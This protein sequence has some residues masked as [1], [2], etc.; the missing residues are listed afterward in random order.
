M[1]S[2]RLSWVIKELSDFSNFAKH[3]KVLESPW[4]FYFGLIVKFV[5]GIFCFPI[6]LKLIGGGEFEVKEFMT[7]YIYKEIFVDK[8]YDLPALQGN[9][10]T[11]IDVGANTGLF[12]IR[13]K[14]Q[15]NNSTLHCFEPFPSN[16]AQLQRNIDRSQLSDV[17]ISMK[18]VGNSARKQKLFVHSKNVGGHSIYAKATDGNRYVDI[19]LVDIRQIINLLNGR[20]CDLLKLDCEGAEYEIIKSMDRDTASRIKLII[21]EASP[22]LYD[23]HE[24]NRHLSD[25]GYSVERKKGLSVA[26]Y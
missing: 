9:N 24:L 20:D 4:K 22:E 1:K 8:C 12:A 2:W 17:N 15:Y 6:T 11:I 21:F 5:P 10:P 7:L 26:S 23:L 14:Q 13:M 18:G 19:E 3:K 25:I 16:Y